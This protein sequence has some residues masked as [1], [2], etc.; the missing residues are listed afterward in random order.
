MAKKTSKTKLTQQEKNRIDIVRIRLAVL[1]QRI[2]ARRVEGQA[3]WM[4]SE[5]RQQLGLVPET[6]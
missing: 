5:F 6:A 4:L 2:R 1:R 3:L